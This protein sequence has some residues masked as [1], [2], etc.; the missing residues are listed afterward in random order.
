[1]PSVPFSNGAG[2]IK[3]TLLSQSSP[4]LDALFL[5]YI[6]RH[7]WSWR[8]WAGPDP[9]P[10]EVPTSLCHGSV[11]KRCSG[12]FLGQS[13]FWLYSTVS[14]GWVLPSWTISSQS[15][16]TGQ[17]NCQPTKSFNYLFSQF[18]T[19]NLVCSHFQWHL[20]WTR[21]SGWRWD[22][23]TWLSWPLQLTCFTSARRLTLWSFWDLLLHKC[24]SRRNFS[25]LTPSPTTS[26]TRP[27]HSPSWSSESSPRHSLLATMVPCDWMFVWCEALTMTCMQDIILVRC[28]SW[29][30][31]VSWSR[32]RIIVSFCRFDPLRPA[33]NGGATLMSS[34]FKFTCRMKEQI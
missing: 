26:S 10:W 32:P 17:C 28:F 12:K 27:V 34:L 6:P 29:S 18:S 33:V 11:V 1:M 30:I 24:T 15:R 19:E 9:S 7:R 22:A 21:L 13:L 4:Y 5:T 23:S 8:Q 31:K 25:S 20:V 14:L 2:I 3:L 16:A